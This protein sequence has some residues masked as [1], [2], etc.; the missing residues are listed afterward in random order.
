MAELLAAAK[1]NGLSDDEIEQA[2]I[3]AAAFYGNVGN[4]KSFGDTKFVPALPAERLHVLMTAGAADAAK[5]ATLWSTCA[6]RMYSLPPR[7]RQLGLGAANGVSTYFSANAEAADADVAGKFLESLNL[8]PYNTRLMKAAD[9]TYEVLVA[10]A[11][12][13]AAHITHT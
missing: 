11:S 10:S 6:P 1:A 7:Q 3:Y 8:S 9:G 5:V 4:Y 13:G 12:E 2:M